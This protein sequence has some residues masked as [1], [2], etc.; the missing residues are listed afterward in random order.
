MT[1]TVPGKPVDPVLGALLLASLGYAL[2]QTM[3]APALPHLAQT[4]DTTSSTTAWVLTG[5]LLSASVCTPLAGKLGDLF[6]K[7]RV[8]TYILVIL[9]IGSIICATAGSIEVL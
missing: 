1:H 6:G 9:S 8:L 7:G 5:Y 3:V 4:F 2:S